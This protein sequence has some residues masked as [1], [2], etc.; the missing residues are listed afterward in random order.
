MLVVG[1]REWD[2]CSR[3]RQ[4][5]LGS[6]QLRRHGVA[7]L[8]GGVSPRPLK[9]QRKTKGCLKL[10]LPGST[11]TE[12]GGEPPERV[13]A[14][15]QS[16]RCTLIFGRAVVSARL[17]ERK[18]AST[19]GVLFAHVMMMASCSSV[20]CMADYSTHTETASQ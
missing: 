7:R 15:D 2:D 20:S 19:S 16:A 13:L 3:F 9:L 11:A 1:I 17:P 18:T 6:A 5:P 14:Y 12:K 8:G 10:C 4:F